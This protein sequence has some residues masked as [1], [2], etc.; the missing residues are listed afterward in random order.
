LLS[1]T[2]RSA[3]GSTSLGVTAMVVA[4]SLMNGYT[5]DLQE[6]ML[7]G[8]ALIIAPVTGQ[9]KV[10]A[11]ERLA[12]VADLPGVAALS[13]AVFTQGALSRPATPGAHAVTLRGVLPGADRFVPQAQR[14]EVVDGIAGVVM[15][16][17][18]AQRLAVVEGDLVQV[19]FLDQKR[20]ASPFRFKTLRMSG[21]FETGFAQFDQ[22]YAVVDRRVVDAVVGAGLWE[23][24]VDPEDS[25]DQTRE[26]IQAMLGD[27]FLVQDWRHSRG[28]ALLFDA[29]R[30]QKWALFLMLGLIVVVSTFN[31]ASTLIVLVRE[32]MRDIGSLVAMGLRPAGVRAVFVMCGVG[33]GAAG[34]LLGLLMGVALSWLLT[35][36][37]LL[38]FP[39]EVST[40]YFIDS[41]PFR[42]EPLDLVL[43]GTFALLVTLGASLFPASR[44]AALEATVCLRYE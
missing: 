11:Q 39:P 3:L 41:V 32:R 35:V 2:A 40:I 18:L 26:R 10:E 8:G 4:T 17:V 37:R 12:G 21:T 44:A 13:Y 31:V 28:N 5:H 24:A 6:R 25:V 30:L 19:V 42:V 43:I 36:F 16:K 1:G 29:L 38:R 27:D 9:A 22:S 33:L 23:V 14:L 15:G 20:D 7:F 34:T